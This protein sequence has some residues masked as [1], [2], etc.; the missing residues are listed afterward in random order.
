MNDLLTHNI[1]ITENGVIFRKPLDEETYL[2]T[3]LVSDWVFDIL[4]K[5]SLEE[6][7]RQIEIILDNNK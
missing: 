2:F 7:Q 6:V 4:K 1:T 3:W 5:W